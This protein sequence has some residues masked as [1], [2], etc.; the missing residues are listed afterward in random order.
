MV[1]QTVHFHET[2]KIEARRLGLDLY[3]KLTRPIQDRLAFGAGIPVSVA[4]TPEYV[5]CE[6][7]E[8]VVI[9][10]VLG[11]ISFHMKRFEAVDWISQWTKRLGSGH[12]LPVPIDSAWRNVEEEFDGVP[13]LTELYDVDDLESITVDEIVL[14]VLRLLQKDSPDGESKKPSL[15]VSHAKAD[16]KATN[17][18]AKMIA[19]YAK[20]RITGDAF[21]DRTELFSGEPL[22]E[23][24]E[25][26]SRQWCLR[27]DSWRHL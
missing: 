16:L 21:F 26:G 20:T 12:V 10:P 24:T 3:D 19:N 13:L 17:R 25:S 8:T 1:I 23:T 7:A 11:T 6:A 2:D 15:F 4:A 22:E 5:D 9:V 18:A 27:C 14:A